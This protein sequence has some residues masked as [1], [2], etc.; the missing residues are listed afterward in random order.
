M[1]ARPALLSRLPSIFAVAF[2]LL[3][4]PAISA[5]ETAQKTVSQPQVA[6]PLAAPAANKKE[7]SAAAKA[8]L[9]Q[10]KALGISLL[11]SLANDARNYQDQRLRARTLSRIAD[12]LWESDPEQGRSLFRKAWDAADAADQ[13]AARKLSEERQRQQSNNPNG[14]IAL[15]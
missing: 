6:T 15:G 8:R 7:T 13:E 11:V 10:K 4:A 3:L 2:L 5:Q 9:E 1:M 14:P 12:A